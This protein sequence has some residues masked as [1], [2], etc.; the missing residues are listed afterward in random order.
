ML[1]NSLKNIKTKNKKKGKTKLYFKNVSEK[2]IKQS[3]SSLNF[4]FY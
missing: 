3:S 4:V 1:Q 2:C